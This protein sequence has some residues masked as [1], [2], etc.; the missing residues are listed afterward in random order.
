LATAM[1]PLFAV[2]RRQTAHRSASDPLR[3]R[4]Y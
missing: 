4:H 1:A 3:L 2:L